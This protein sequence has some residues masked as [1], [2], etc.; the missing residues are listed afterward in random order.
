[1]VDKESK[2][3]ITVDSSQAEGALGRLTEKEKKLGEATGFTAKSF[4]DLE[5]KYNRAEG[6]TEYA[7]KVEALDKSYRQG[8]ISSKQLSQELSF[9]QK[10][11]Q[12]AGGSTAGFGQAVE[13]AQKKV[14]AAADALKKKTDALKA[15]AD[16]SK[17][18]AESNN[19]LQNKLVQL[20]S[21]TFL[22]EKGFQVL[23]GAVTGVFSSLDEAARIEGLNRGFESLQT[24]AGNVADE[25][26]GKLRTAT[27][28]YISDVD[29]MKSANQAV[30]L[31]LPTEGFDQLAGAAVKLGQAMGITATQA[32]DSLT[33]GIGR[34]SKLVLDNLGIIVEAEKAYDR[35]AKRLGVTAEALTDVQKKEAF[36]QAAQEAILAKSSQLS[37]VQETA[38]SATTKLSAT[39]DN[40]RK[41]ALETLRMS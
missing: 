33:I 12:E 34:Q 10:K 36:Y 4:S 38:A 31:G 41:S 21:A 37:D 14:V 39:F 22:A 35:Y 16:A 30:L 7:R 19:F 20:T 3:R 15:S 2:F 32:I 23:K 25:F 26:L 8:A 1:V 5:N 29:L 6:I 13:Q 9:L 24:A 11:F 17:A 18:A 40:L 27:H 28:G